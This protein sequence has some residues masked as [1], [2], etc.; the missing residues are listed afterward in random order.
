[1]SFLENELGCRWYTPSVSVIPKKTNF[2]FSWLDHSEKP[3]IRVRNDFYFEAFDPIWAARNRMN[4][5]LGFDKTNP[6]PGG[7][8]NYWAVHTFY[9]LMPP[10][11][12]YDKHTEYY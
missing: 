6:Q 1:M 7:T 10:T 5:T 9:P 12:F 2:S 3:G 11:E 8:E 4:G